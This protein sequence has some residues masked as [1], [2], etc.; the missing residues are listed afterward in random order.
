MPLFESHP[1]KGM[2][3]RILASVSGMVAIYMV[4]IVASGFY[5]LRL[6]RDV[7]AQWRQRLYR[8]VPKEDYDAMVENPAARS[9]RIFYISAVIGIAV[10]VVAFLL[11]LRFWYAP[12]QADHIIPRFFDVIL[13]T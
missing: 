6:Q 3:R 1:N 10:A 7:R 4:S 12:S 13:R 8:F 2:F 5:Y 9:E 11:G